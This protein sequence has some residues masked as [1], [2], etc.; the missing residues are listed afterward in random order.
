MWGPS[1]RW[2]RA[3]PA[4]YQFHR[5]LGTDPR[6]DGGWQ[7]SLPDHINIAR[8]GLPQTYEAAKVALAKCAKIDE[9][10]E[11]ADKAQALASYARMADDDELFK[12]AVRIQARAVRRAGELLKQFDGRGNNQHTVGAYGIPQREAARRAEMSEHQ[13]LQASRVA[14]VPEEQFDD[15]IGNDNPPTVTAIAE[16]GTTHRTAMP[17]DGFKQATLLLGTVRRFAEFCS[18]HDPEFVAN[19]ILSSEADEVREVVGTIDNW[20]DR[21][22]VNLKG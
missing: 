5:T 7:L 8:A 21:F 20:L 14:N 13:Q 11:W 18:Q 22:V 10:K 12:M 3:A 17:P 4:P 1:H 9:C 15:A 2:G 6:S 16:M 19:G